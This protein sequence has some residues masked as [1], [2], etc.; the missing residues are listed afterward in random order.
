MS[1]KMVFAGVTFG[2]MIQGKMHDFYVYSYW[3]HEPYVLDVER[4]VIYY[5][6]RHSPHGKLVGVTHEG[7]ERELI[8]QYINDHLEPDWNGRLICVCR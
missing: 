1:E 5:N 8:T 7:C 2:G 4:L 3:S 6:S